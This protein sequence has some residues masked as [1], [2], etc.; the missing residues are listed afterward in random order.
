MIIGKKHGCHP[1]GQIVSVRREKEPVLPAKKI[2]FEL[3]RD[4]T[5]E[6]LHRCAETICP[7]PG[8]SF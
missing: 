1:R 4:M 7:F 8:L 3:K 6:R 2:H 5:L